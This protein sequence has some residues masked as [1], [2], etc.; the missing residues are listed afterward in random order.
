MIRN[1]VAWADDRRLAVLRTSRA[2]QVKAIEP[3][4]GT[5][6]HFSSVI[7]VERLRSRWN[8]EIK[9]SRRS[10]ELF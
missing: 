8:M 3:N 9:I 2:V 6:E 4:S 5:V 10:D 7:L 1:V